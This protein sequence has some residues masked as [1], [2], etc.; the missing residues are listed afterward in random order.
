MPQDAKNMLRNRGKE[1][2]GQR[3]ATKHECEELKGGVWV[4][5]LEALKRQTQPTVDDQSC[6]CAKKHIVE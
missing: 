3:W 5:P 1:V 6:Q 4:E 2:A